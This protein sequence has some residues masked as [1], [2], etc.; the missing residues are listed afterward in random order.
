MFLYKF[1]W[2]CKDNPMGVVKITYKHHPTSEECSPCIRKGLSGIFHVSY[3]L[4]IHI[5][6]VYQIVC[7]FQ[8]KS[9]AGVKFSQNC[10]MPWTKKVLIILHQEQS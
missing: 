1:V 8:D 4:Q 6:V 5:S 3:F 2:I 9:N 7:I 10:N